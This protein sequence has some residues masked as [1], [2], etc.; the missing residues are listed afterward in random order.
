[1]SFYSIPERLWLLAKHIICTRHFR[2]LKTGKKAWLSDR[3]AGRSTG[4]AKNIIFLSSFET[5]DERGY[6]FIANRQGSELESPIMGIYRI[7]GIC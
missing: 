4:R 1:M 3:V 6:F 5:K 7:T 2:L